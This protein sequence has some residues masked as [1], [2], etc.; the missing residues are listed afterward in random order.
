MTEEGET[1]QR[2]EPERET[3]GGDCLTELKDIA[4]LM[5]A[6]ITEQRLATNTE[7]LRL[8]ERMKAEGRKKRGKS[9]TAHQVNPVRVVSVQPNSSFTVWAM[10]PNVFQM[11][12]DQDRDRIRMERIL[13]TLPHC[14]Q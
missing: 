14:Q 2:W 8:R 1:S 6:P 11:A 12:Q 3:P 5:V 7:Y 4:H 13:N 10:G 9:R